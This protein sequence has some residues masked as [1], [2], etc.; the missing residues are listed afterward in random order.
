VE[1][2]K[3]NGNRRNIDGET[4]HNQAG[5]RRGTNAMKAGDLPVDTQNLLVLLYDLAQRI[6]SIIPKECK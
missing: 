4:L 2:K 3:P 6:E 5:D 1:G